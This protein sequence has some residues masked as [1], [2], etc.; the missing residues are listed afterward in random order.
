[1]VDLARH[2]SGAKN[3]DN[4]PDPPSPA[5][6][7]LNQPHD[8]HGP[9][10]ALAANGECWYNVQ[11][12]LCGGFASNESLSVGQLTI[13]AYFSNSVYLRMKTGSQSSAIEVMANQEG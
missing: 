4:L 9:N 7:R 3:I 8:R 11:S 6:I 5:Q 10:C 2:R 12:A 1:M 13:K